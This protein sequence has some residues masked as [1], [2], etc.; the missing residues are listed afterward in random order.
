M[1]IL[2]YKHG[3]NRRMRREGERELRKNMEL[4]LD[5]K[6]LFYNLIFTYPYIDYEE[7]YN[8]CLIVNEN[9]TKYIER[10]GRFKYTEPN[11]YWF[12]DAFAPVE[13]PYS[14]TFGVMEFIRRINGQKVRG[15]LGGSF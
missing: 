11:K 6:A 4:Y 3:T 5:V 12:R 10:I 14:V 2:S 13:K 9:I 15:K 7:A 1:K 8:E